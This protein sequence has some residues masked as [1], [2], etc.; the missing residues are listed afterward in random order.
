VKADVL[1]LKDPTYK[2]LNFCS[3]I[4]GSAWNDTNNDFATCRNPEHMHG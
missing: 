2:R 1:A 3:I 4:L